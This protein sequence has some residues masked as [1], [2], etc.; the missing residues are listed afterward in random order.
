MTTQYDNHPLKW[1]ILTTDE[2][3]KRWKFFNFSLYFRDLNFPMN[4]FKDGEEMKFV[5][6]SVDYLNALNDRFMEDPK[7]AYYLLFNLGF[8]I[9]LSEY[10]PHLMMNSNLKMDT[11]LDVSFCCIDFK[12]IFLLKFT[13]FFQKISRYQ[14]TFNY[15]IIKTLTT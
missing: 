4:N 11:K 5:V 9:T 14:L 12:L 8:Y 3:N 1:Q 13:I 6:K 2:A 15:I 7:F 10:E